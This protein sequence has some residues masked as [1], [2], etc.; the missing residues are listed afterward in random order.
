M[1]GKR[2]SK[3]KNDENKYSKVS[4]CV[5]VKIRKDTKG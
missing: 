3:K 5:S 4:F 1:R 2:P